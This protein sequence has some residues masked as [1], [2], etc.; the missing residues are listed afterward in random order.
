MIVPTNLMVV[1]KEKGVYINKLP[2][3]R[4][5]LWPG[6]NILNF[7]CNPSGSRVSADIHRFTVKNNGFQGFLKHNGWKIFMLG[8]LMHNSL[9]KLQGGFCHDET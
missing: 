5:I 1:K 3:N 8:L 9:P 2:I 6:S 7:T 4:P